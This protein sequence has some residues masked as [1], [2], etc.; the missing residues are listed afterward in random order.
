MKKILV[1]VLVL[2]MGNGLWCDLQD[3]YKKGTIVLKGVAGF[4]E[5]IDWEDLFYDPYKDMVVALDGSVFVS[6]S[7][8]HNVFKF[9]KQ[10][11]LVKKLGSRGVG[12]GDFNFPLDLSIMDGKYLV[13]EESGSNRR[14]SI[15]DLEGKFTKVVKT[16]TSIFYLTAL[17]DNRVAYFFFKQHA[18]KK[19]GYQSIVYIIIKDINTGKEKVL[20]KITL[21]NRSRIILDRGMSTGLGNFFGQVYLAQTINGNLAVG[22]SNQPKIKIYSPDGDMIHSFDL[23]IKPIAVDNKYLEEF[24]DNVMTHLKKEG[25]RYKYMNRT[26]KFWHELY[27][28]TFPKFDY[29]TIFEKCLPLYKEILVDSEGNFLVFKYTQCQENCN[30]IFQV[31]SKKGEFICETV[32]DRGKYELN[33]DRRFKRI[34]F[35]SEGIFGLFIEKGDEDEILRLIKSNYNPAP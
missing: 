31:Y 17:R 2:L 1:A 33:I 20:Q 28:K 30:P 13:V 32:L 8:T 4:G 7:R 15:W 25:E 34:C 29:S 5:G 24:R 23:K 19:N 27:K 10:G 12:P 26:E 14:F 21:L 6:N 18:E 9:D 16:N 3:H 22:I 11:K 35:T